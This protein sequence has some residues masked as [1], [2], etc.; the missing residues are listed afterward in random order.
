MKD[1]PAFELAFMDLGMAM[2]VAADKAARAADALREFAETPE[3][4]LDEDPWLIE[5]DA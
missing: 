5:A 1:Q 3:L 4:A 2:D